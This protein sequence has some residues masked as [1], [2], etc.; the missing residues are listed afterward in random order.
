MFSMQSV[1]TPHFA[2]PGFGY[3][4][5]FRENKRLE[6]IDRVLKNQALLFSNFYV[7]PCMLGTN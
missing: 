7:A 3:G 1:T 4:R 2:A 5:D 6:G